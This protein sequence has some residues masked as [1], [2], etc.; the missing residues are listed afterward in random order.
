MDSDGPH[1]Q[2]GGTDSETGAKVLPFRGEWFGSPDELVPF[3]PRARAEKNASGGGTNAAANRTEPVT[4]QEESAPSRPAEPMGQPHVG[5]DDF[6]PGSQT[7]A[8]WS[9]SRLRPTPRPRRSPP[10]ARWVP[11]AV[12][13]GW[14]WRQRFLGSW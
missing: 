9:S 5:A 13:V 11:G 7:P 6:G 14:R 1:N 3:G 4:S 12:R 8:I 10:A 2:A